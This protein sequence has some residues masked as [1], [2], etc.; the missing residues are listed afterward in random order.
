MSKSKQEIIDYLATHSGVSRKQA[1]LMLDT[2]VRLACREA[3]NGFTIPG[4]CKLELVHRD[5]RKGRNPRTG[6]EIDIPAREVLKIKPLKKAKDAV[7]RAP[8]LHEETEPPTPPPPPRPKT[9]PSQGEKQASGPIYITFRCTSCQREIEASTD[10]AGM[11]A[12]CPGCGAPIRVPSTAAIS[13]L[14]QMEEIA[15]KELSPE[16]A[17][18]QKAEKKGDEDWQKGSTIRIEMP[19]DFKMPKAVKRTVYIKRRK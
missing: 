7:E 13:E 17:A 3:R 5:A 2:L 14:A 9:E 11:Q 15:E 10:M 4:L 19:E 8:V 12:E 1:A 6:E 18:E 16:E